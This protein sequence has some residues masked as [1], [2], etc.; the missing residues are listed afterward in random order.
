MYKQHKYIL[1]LCIIAM[2]CISVLNAGEVHFRE[3]GTTSFDTNLVQIKFRVELAPLLMSLKQMKGHFEYAERLYTNGRFADTLDWTERAAYQEGLDHLIS[4]SKFL[5]QR[6][7]NM[8][9]LQDPIFS[10]N[11]LDLVNRSGSRSKRGIAAIVF[12]LISTIVSAS[13]EAI[14]QQRQ[15]VRLDKEAKIASERTHDALHLGLASAKRLDILDSLVTKN[16]QMMMK[17]IGRLHIAVNSGRMEHMIEIGEER[18]ASA[19]D[20]FNAA[21]QNKVHVSL[22]T[23]RKTEDIAKILE[24]E[25][26]NRNMLPMVQRLSDITQVPASFILDT[27]GFSVLAHIPA[28]PR[29]T[30][31]FIYSFVP[32]P[33]HVHEDFY[34]KVLVRNHRIAVSPN[35]DKFQLITDEDFA[36]CV[37]IGSFYLCTENNVVI[38][39]PVGDKF[40]RKDDAL[41]LFALF[42]QQYDMAQVC[43]DIQFD[44]APATVVQT[45]VNSFVSYSSA[46]HQG[47]ISCPQGRNGTSARHAPFSANS[48]SPID[49]E[50]GCVARTATHIFASPGDP[51]IRKWDVTYT[52]ERNSLQPSAD[53]N[54]ADFA[55]GV[56]NGTIEIE[57]P[58]HF[59]LSQAKASWSKMNYER[60]QN[61]VIQEHL[62]PTHQ[63]QWISV[64]MAIILVLVIVTFPILCFFIYKKKFKWITK[65]AA[66][67]AEIIS[68]S[69]ARPV[70]QQQQQPCKAE[71]AAP[72]L[73]QQ[74]QQPVYPICT[75][76]QIENERRLQQHQEAAALLAIQQA[77]RRRDP[78]G[79]L[80][81][82]R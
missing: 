55:T 18:V 79:S 16:G 32:L 77:D 5:I 50:P 24:E 74:Q 69:Q 66:A 30:I 6:T 3:V 57:D 82:R 34:S 28:A 72:P 52:Y 26:F 44:K 7:E 1:S 4:R 47:T 80:S 29:D 54:M 56:S 68:P 70:P 59:T 75:F 9:H 8:I 65:A 15:I 23:S 64:G 38:R 61:K 10:Q 48:M 49:L 17:N 58:D 13:I 31:L 33:V 71:A 73:Y 22:I 76:D 62:V 51:V 20:Q 37:Q 60:T 39:A 42:K 41:C 36:A 81:A 67:A 2:Q 46:P 21:T 35:H 78:F 25:T 45:G 63:H 19:E 27:E 53:F 40:W 11:Q 43:C 12:F 14:Y